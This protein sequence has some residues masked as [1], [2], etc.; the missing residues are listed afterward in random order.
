MSEVLM[1]R[2][3]DTM[4][5]GV[6]STWHKKPGEQ[7]AEG[8]SLVDI[9]TDKALMEYEADMAGVL[10]TILVEEGQSAAIGTPIAVI[11]APGEAAASA[12][13]AA[14]SAPEPAAAPAQA[15][16]SGQAQAVRP[17][18]ATTPGQ[19][20]PAEPAPAGGQ[21]A[22]AEP[23]PAPASAQNGHGR[24]PS[25]PLARRIARENNIDLGSLTG[26]GPGGRIVRA[27]VE[28]AVAAPR[29]APVTAPA[30]PATTAPAAPAPVRQVEVTADDEE[31]PLSRIRQITARRLTESMQSAPHFYL[32]RHV[33]VGELLAF[34]AS[35]NERLTAAGEPKVSVNDLIVRACA[36]ALRAHP[37]LNASFAG[38]HMVIHKRIHVGVAVALEDGLVVPVVRD[39][40]RKAV[41]EIARETRELAGRAREQRLKPDEMSGST[42]TV[43]N[44]GM[45]GI[46]A[47]T[48][49]INPPE[50]AILAVGASRQEVVFRDG[51]PVP[52]DRMTI[53]LSVDHRAADGATAAK[54][55]AKVVDL[56]QDPIRILA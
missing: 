13:P 34:R 44:L 35:L 3:S 23:T 43:S 39:A 36:A 10:E 1:P 29:P 11:R 24:P 37:N 25:S 50:A 17:E 52:A 40:D 30:A 41:T 33:D 38:D 9:E 20:V 18:A 42:F 27:D 19:A 15:A 2:L 53:T 47:F 51:Q 6:I 22:A 55:L 7:V 32:T 54:F 31:V 49:V 12:A 48:A 5:E 8:E 16:A 4:E 26:S 21:A 56:L 45:F 14:P 46:D 28:A